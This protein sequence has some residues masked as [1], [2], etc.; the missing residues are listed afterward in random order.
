MSD[1]SLIP[2]ERIQSRILVLR[3]QRVVMD[4]DLANLYGVTTK[5]LLEQV[6]RNLKRFP[7]DFCFQLDRQEVANLRS[8]IATASG[9]HG[10][11]RTLPWAFTEHGAIMAANVL[12]SDAA[13]EM[14]VHVVRAFIRLRQL[15]IN[16][17]VLAGK[18]A[19]LDARLGEHDEQLAAIV[20]AIRQLTTPDAPTHGRK[21][22]FHQGNR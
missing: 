17:K 14:S 7:V 16:H 5:R 12:N 2:V 1:E 10:G 19:E 18:L 20:A 6:R 13:V 4:H 9:E 8:Q 21:M 22:G 15:M 11:R 3:G